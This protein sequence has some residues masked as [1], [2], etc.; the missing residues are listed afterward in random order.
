MLPSKQTHSCPNQTLRLLSQ[1]CFS[2]LSSPLH[3]HCHCLFPD[4]S[5]C[6]FELQQLSPNWVF[7]PLCLLSLPFVFYRTVEGKKEGREGV[8]RGRKE[9]MKE[10][11]K[12]E[13]KRET[14]KKKILIIFFLCLNSYFGSL[15]T[16]KSAS[17]FWLIPN[18]LSHSV[19][20]LS[21][22]CHLHHSLICTLL[23][24]LVLPAQVRLVDR[25]M[26]SDTLFLL[27]P[28]PELFSPGISY[29]TFLPQLKYHLLQ[30]AFPDFSSKCFEGL[31]AP[32]SHIYTPIVVLNFELQMTCV[33]VI[34]YFS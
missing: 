8:M 21:F 28:P 33:S 23:F 30:E 34:S 29:T 20:K 11:K 7:S 26:A 2:I 24:F 10:G 31:Y 22:W 15:P 18:H 27:S 17:L 16:G 4:A 6:S 5:C 19:T 9:G 13:R 1:K 14:G 32:T 25:F 3:F 12:R